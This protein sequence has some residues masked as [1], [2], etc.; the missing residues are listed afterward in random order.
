MFRLSYRT[1]TFVL[2]ATGVL[3]SWTTEQE[4][5][6]LTQYIYDALLLVAN[7][8]LSIHTLQAMYA[9]IG[10][11]THFQDILLSILRD[12]LTNTNPQVRLYTLQL[13]N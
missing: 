2:Y 9:E 3:C 6:E 8:K 4:R 1:T 11:D 5:A 10:S 13:F 12:S 7:Q